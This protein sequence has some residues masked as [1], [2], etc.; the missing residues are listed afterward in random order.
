MI[1]LTYDKKKRAWADAD[2]RYYRNVCDGV[3][4]VHGSES[5]TIVRG[6]ENEVIGVTPG[7]TLDREK[8]V[9]LD[10]WKAFRSGEKTDAEA[11][12][13]ALRAYCGI[14]SV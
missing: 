4:L 11:T 8:Q 1:P 2:G 14:P 13:D 5:Y 7:V 9:M 12:A 10:A 6:D 3:H